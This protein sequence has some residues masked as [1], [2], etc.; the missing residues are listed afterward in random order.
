M[1]QEDVTAVATV[2]FASRSLSSRV[3]VPDSVFLSSRTEDRTSAETIRHPSA[4]PIH[5]HRWLL[6]DGLSAVISLAG[7][8]VIVVPARHLAAHRSRGRRRG[9]RLGGDR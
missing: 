9:V 3:V 5:L 1:L 7:L 2:R 4:A 6:R 8:A